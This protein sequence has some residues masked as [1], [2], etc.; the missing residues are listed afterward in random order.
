MV[1]SLS[2]DNPRPKR[3]LHSIYLQSRKISK[4]NSHDPLLG[5]VQHLI[6]GVRLYKAHSEE[7]QDAREKS[8]DISILFG[9]C[10]IDPEVTCQA[11]TARHNI[12]G[13]RRFARGLKSTEL[14]YGTVWAVTIS[15][16]D[17]ARIPP[18]KLDPYVHTAYLSTL[19]ENGGVRAV[20]FIMTV[21]E[22]IAVLGHDKGGHANTELCVLRFAQSLIAS[23]PVVSVLEPGMLEG[24]GTC[25]IRQL[26]FPVT[27]CNNPFK[28]SW[29]E[30][31]NPSNAANCCNR[32]WQGPPCRSSQ[33]SRRS[34]STWL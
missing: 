3:P 31:I 19:I 34:M 18:S 17:F 1:P 22:A 21:A 33:L 9:S 24:T 20:S 4:T 30:V 6:T 16:K 26:G 28:K 5:Y 10:A 23:N 25:Q 8:S 29:T 7:Y 2:H 15:A 12:L 11:S 13:R 32:P 27:Y 14:S